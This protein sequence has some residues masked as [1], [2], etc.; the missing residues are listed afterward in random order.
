MNA[1][2]IAHRLTW[3]SW[4]NF[5]LTN[6]VPRRRLTRF[7][8]WYSKLRLP[9]LTPATLAIWRLFGGLELR[10]A[11]QTRFASL[12]EC[13]TRELIPDARPIEPDPGVLT[14]PCD[15]IVVACGALSG[16]EALQ[17][18][19]RS[20]LIDELLCDA[21]LARSFA[22]GCFVTL[23]LTA[24]MYHRFHAPYD[25]RVEALTYVSG[26][27]WN[28]NPPA[29][30]RIDRLYCRNERAVLRLRLATGH[31]LAL[32]PV[33]AILV[34][35]IRLRFIDIRPHL[36]QRGPHRFACA[37][38]VAKGEE[39]GWF[40]HGSTIVVLAPRGFVPCPGVAPGTRLRMGERLLQLPA[41]ASSPQ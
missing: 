7:M 32:V 5:V 35:S 37:V 30:A 15:A 18:K 40:E 17:A 41:P 12:H 1:R 21:R 27:T 20:Y 28:V 22:D 2:V 25:A 33:G 6:H 39:L 31:G 34:A 13:F 14:S 38:P 4:L 9:L 24:A 10:D 23:R 26:D 3:R 11:R 19:G 36:R 16:G 29:L 8:G